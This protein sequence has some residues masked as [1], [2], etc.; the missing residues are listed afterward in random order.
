MKIKVKNFGV[1]GS[2]DVLHLWVTENAERHTALD[3]MRKQGPAFVCGGKIPNEFY[4]LYAQEGDWLAEKGV[5]YNT[6]I[7]WHF[8]S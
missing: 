3:L 4:A 2:V 1:F 6:R 5:D 8:I 7:G